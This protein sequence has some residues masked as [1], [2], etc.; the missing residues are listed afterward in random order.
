MTAA[1][2]G[3]EGG[4]RSAR[5]MGAPLLPGARPVA[6][7]RPAAGPT[8]PLLQLLLRPANAALVGHPLLRVLDPANELVAEG[9]LLSADS[10]CG[11]PP[12]D[13]RDVSGPSRHN[14]QN[15]GLSHL[16]RS[17]AALRTAR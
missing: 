16:Q 14:P 5:E 10:R 6:A 8:H 3:V 7:P 13:G 9:P 1:S 15:E 4:P 2:W 12:V 17:R 11:S